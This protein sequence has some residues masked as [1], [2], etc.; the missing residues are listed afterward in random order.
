MA[1]TPDQ[2]PN[3]KVNG[4]LAI[5]GGETS[6]RPRDLTRRDEV[7]IRWNKTVDDF[8]IFVD[9]RWERLL[10]LMK[11]H[12]IFMTKEDFYDHDTMA[13]LTSLHLDVN[14]LYIEVQEL[15]KLLGVDL[16]AYQGNT[17][18]R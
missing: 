15:R 9:G 1:T 7:N 2:I 12:D 18:L 8:D 3:L 4:T 13:Y 14:N 6:E 11:L 16:M 17:P 10:V 5:P